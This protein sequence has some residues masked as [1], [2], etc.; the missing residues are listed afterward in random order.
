MSLE[1]INVKGYTTP[2]TFSGFQI[3]IPLQSMAIRRYCEDRGLVFNHHVVENITPD[4]YLVLE[5][6]IR[7]AH[8]YQ[9]IAMCSVGMLPTDSQHRTA[10][11]SLCLD[12]DTSVHF[13]FEQTVVTSQSDIHAVNELISLTNLVSGSPSRLGNF[14]YLSKY[15]S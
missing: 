3:P 2:R 12:Q 7:E 9:A 8:L 5:R 15:S 1:A 14:Q 10:L 13:L 4:T 6:I 11:L